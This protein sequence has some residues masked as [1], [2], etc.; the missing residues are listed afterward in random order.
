M[1]SY[2][3]TVPPGCGDSPTG[4]SSFTVPCISLEDLS[5]QDYLPGGRT[6]V[7]T[8]YKKGS[9]VCSGQYGQFQVLNGLGGQIHR[10]LYV[11]KSVA[12]I[13]G[14]D[15]PGVEI[16][17]DCTDRICADPDTNGGPNGDKGIAI[18]DRG[19]WYVV[20]LAQSSGS[21]GVSLYFGIALGGNPDRTDSENR[22][23]INPVPIFNTSRTG[24]VLLP[25]VPSW[26]SLALPESWTI[27]TGFSTDTPVGLGYVQLVRPSVWGGSS[28]TQAYGLPIDP[29]ERQETDAP[30]VMSAIY[31][32]AVLTLYWSHG[33]VAVELEDLPSGIAVASSDTELDPI[34]VTS[35][36]AGSLQLTAILSRAIQAG[37]VITVTVS[38]GIWTTSED[39]TNV[40]ASIVATQQ[41]IRSSVVF[42]VSRVSYQG[43][44]AGDLVVM[45]D[46]GTRITDAASESRAVLDIVQVINPHRLPHSHQG[47]GSGPYGGGPANFNVATVLS[48][49]EA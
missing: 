36:T 30:E 26:D 29:G 37:E 31:Q 5:P 9:C 14:S 25:T 2:G 19:R 34:T 27:S 8:V 3:L 42:A 10:A 39:V 7:V 38:A 18:R 44:V 45:M 48:R 22:L 24:L 32:A 12:K 28:W 33:T 20:K 35:A 11:G 21:G 13:D 4:F 23:F 47:F 40:E 16:T 17:V 43:I 6:A 46:S 49:E 15:N 1:T 41:D